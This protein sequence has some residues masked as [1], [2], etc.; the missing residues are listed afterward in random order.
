MYFKTLKKEW[1]FKNGM[2]LIKMLSLITLIR[3]L[4]KIIFTSLSS[5]LS[6]D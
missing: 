5:F 6:P 3:A 1:K 4:T 2:F